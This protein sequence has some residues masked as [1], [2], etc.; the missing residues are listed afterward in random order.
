MKKTIQAAAAAAA[1]IAGAQ[2]ASAETQVLFNSFIPQGHIFNQGV[3]LP[4][5]EMVEE[6]TEGRVVF[7]V[8]A[9]TLAPPPAQFDGIRKGVFDGGYSSTVFLEK[10][11]P[12]SHLGA[13]PFGTFGAEANS[14]AMWE[15]YEKYLA[16]ADEFRD[17]QLLAL[18]VLLPGQIMSTEDP[19]DSVESLDGVKI[20]AMPG[21]TAD[22]LDAAGGTVISSPAVQAYEIISSGAV[23]GMAGLSLFDYEMFKVSQYGRNATLIHGGATA[24]VFALMMNK[25]KW[26]EISPE[27]Q[28]IILNSAHKDL[29]KLAS[30]Y[31]RESDALMAKMAERG[32]EVKPASEAFLADLQKAA[33]P[34]IDAWIAKADEQGVPG[35]EAL[36]FYRERAAKYAEELKAGN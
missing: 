8:P 18:V 7:E 29:A 26:A 2:T 13:L 36:E 21:A 12:L 20:W 19:V 33:Q 10:F 5:L 9:T 16:A 1:L 27:D 6:K 23:T 35:R 22:M 25:R 31:D 3:L 28:E 32:V 34:Q 15:T 30:V 17:V 24:P 11:A 4:W 14:R